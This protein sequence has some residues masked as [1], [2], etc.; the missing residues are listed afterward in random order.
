[1]TRLIKGLCKLGFILSFFTLVL[2]IA[3]WSK[4]ND[5]QRQKLSADIQHYQQSGELRLHFGNGLVFTP[6]RIYREPPQDPNINTQTGDGKD[7]QTTDQVA[8]LESMMHSLESLSSSEINFACSRIQT[9]AIEAPQQKAIYRWRDENGK[10]HFS[11]QKP[12]QERELSVQHY[13]QSLSY[14]N[15]SLFDEHSPITAMRRDRISADVKQIYNLLNKNLGFKNIRAVDLN[16]RLFDQQEDFQNHKQN[17]APKLNTNTGFYS[18]KRNEA[19]VYVWPERDNFTHSVIRHES[20]HVIM[21]GLLGITPI[22]FTE[23]I[24]EYFERLHLS[25]QQKRIALAKDHLATLRPLAQ[26]NILL[27]WQQFW[28]KSPQAFYDNPEQNYAQAWAFIHFLLS[29]DEGRELFKNMLNYF[30]QNPCQNIDMIEWINRD[31][32]GGLKQFS[33]DFQM[34][35]INNKFNDHY[36]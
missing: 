9:H 20:T 30:Y 27:D 19:A 1:M 18:Y 25:G 12:E 10:L 26:Q 8:L 31:Y 36:Y 6:F 34:A 22:W 16:I 11:D 5:K 4:L 13:E 15:L 35:L 24:A 2:S 33:L 3:Y 21:A 23:G 28:T 14:F 29:S 32:P 17:V 7:L